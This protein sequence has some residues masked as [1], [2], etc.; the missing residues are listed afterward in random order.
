MNDKRQRIIPV[1]P[2]NHEKRLELAKL[3]IEAGFTV[4]EGKDKV[5]GKTVYFVEYWE[6]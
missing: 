3:L 4:R 6:E 5:D 2:F 1:A